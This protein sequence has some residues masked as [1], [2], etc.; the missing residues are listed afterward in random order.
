MQFAIYIGGIVKTL[1]KKTLHFKTQFPIT[2]HKHEQAD[3]QDTTDVHPSTREEFGIK[4]IHSS[5]C[6]EMVRIH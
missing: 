1:K 6:L 4:E 2:N 3:L 5:Y